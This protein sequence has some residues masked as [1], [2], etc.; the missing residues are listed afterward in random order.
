MD[1]EQGWL[2][3]SYLEPED[4]SAESAIST[5]YKLGGETDNLVVSSFMKSSISLSLNL[6]M[7][8]SSFVSCS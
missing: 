3:A 8:F 2:P 5:T 1:E 7:V 6:L 4:G